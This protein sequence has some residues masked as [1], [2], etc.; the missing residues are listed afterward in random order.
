MLRGD[1]PLLPRGGNGA[2]GGAKP[3]GRRG[4]APGS[5]RL[6]AGG[7]AARSAW[8]GVGWAA[9]RRT[10]GAAK[11]HRVAPGARRSAGC[12][13]LGTSGGGITLGW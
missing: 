12:V 11:Y 9:G 10:G 2:A 3:S 1:I 8:E 5:F 7:S 13:P 4:A 6:I